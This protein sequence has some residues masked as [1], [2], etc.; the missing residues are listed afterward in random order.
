MDRALLFFSCRVASSRNSSN[1]SFVNF[2]F[3]D[4]FIE[5]G[6]VS[7]MT[8]KFLCLLMLKIQVDSQLL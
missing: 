2:D 6:R 4:Q 8:V 7:R 1:Q 5:P 3:V